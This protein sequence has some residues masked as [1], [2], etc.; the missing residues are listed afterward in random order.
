MFFCDT[1]SI[2]RAKWS[3]REAGDVFQ[4]FKITK[5]RREAY[6]DMKI[7]HVHPTYEIYYLLSGT[8]RMLLDDS[9]Y[10]LT[11]GD[12]VFI[13]MDTI[14]RTTHVNDGMHERIAVTFGDSAIPDLKYAGSELSLVMRLVRL[15]RPKAS[16]CAPERL[17]VLANSSCRTS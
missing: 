3:R 10:M 1:R 15:G 2:I 12:L 8:R 14:H 6:F 4:G 11:Q 7:S 13:P 17:T 9:I 5:I 16:N